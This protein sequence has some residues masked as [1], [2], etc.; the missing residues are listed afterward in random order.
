MQCIPRLKL[1][2]ATA[3]NIRGLPETPASLFPMVRSTS[4]MLKGINARDQLQQRL[5]TSPSSASPTQTF[6]CIL[7]IHPTP[8]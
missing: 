5:I 2:L 7:H 8:Q 1:Q 3:F 4:Q 6:K